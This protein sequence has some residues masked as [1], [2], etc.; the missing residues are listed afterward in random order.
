MPYVGLAPVEDRLRLS[1]S[2]YSPYQVIHTS[3]YLLVWFRDSVNNGS[4]SPRTTETGQCSAAIESSYAVAKPKLRHLL[5][6]I[7]VCSEE[8]NNPS[9]TRRQLDLLSPINLPF[10]PSLLVSFAYFG[11]VKGVR[12]VACWK[13]VG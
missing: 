13:R 5:L 6:V 1:G 10:H 4:Q 7:S 2:A 8:A 12:G 9:A 3:Q 11:L